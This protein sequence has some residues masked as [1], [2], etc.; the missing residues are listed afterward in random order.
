MTI[1]PPP[2]R[3]TLVARV[4]PRLIWRHEDDKTRQQRVDSLFELS[5]LIRHTSQKLAFGDIADGIP[6]TACGVQPESRVL[7][8]AKR[9][10]K[11]RD[12]RFDHGRRLV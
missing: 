5:G 4:L 8:A 12:E 10:F 7:Q 2:A 11:G 3:T 9:V 1:A 6:D